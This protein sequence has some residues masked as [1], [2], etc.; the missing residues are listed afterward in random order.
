MFLL[1]SLLGC[2]PV[3]SILTA[4]VDNQSGSA[5]HIWDP[6]VD[7]IGEDNKVE[8]FKVADLYVEPAVRVRN[9]V[10]DASITLAYGW[11][12]EEVGRQDIPFTV[13]CDYEDD[14]LRGTLDVMFDGYSFFVQSTDDVR[15]IEGREDD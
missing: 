12:G 15:C 5:V 10:A 13:P 8:E 14:I 11:N 2:G 3:G 4:N 1:L 9:N 6:S 7:D